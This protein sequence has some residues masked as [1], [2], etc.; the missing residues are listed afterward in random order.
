MRG[1][2]SPNRRSCCY[3]GADG[4]LQQSMRASL[5]TRYAELNRPFRG[6]Q[7]RLAIFAAC[8]FLTPVLAAE[9]PVVTTAPGKPVWAKSLD[10]PGLPNLHG[11]S[12]T[13]FRGA[14]PTAEGMKQLEALGVKTV[15]SFRAHHSDTDLLK[16]TKLTGIS[17]PMNTWSPTEAQ[18]V[19]FLRVVN[20]PKQQPVFVHCQHGADRTGMMCAIY[21]VAVCGWSKEEAT[22]EMTQGGFNF[23]PMWTNLPKFVKELDID[24]I[25]KK[26]L[27][28]SEKK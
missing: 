3:H 9:E 16:G 10:K 19:Q 12:G 18:V 20:D 24:A 11:I 13:L 4:A 22:K 21:R 6:F 7:I 1:L 26:A 14:Q 2:L 5:M 28:G 25:K 23:H 27:E 15:I 8:V 17:I